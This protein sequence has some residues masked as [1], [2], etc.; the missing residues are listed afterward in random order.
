[1]WHSTVD[2]A[3]RNHTKANMK[4]CHTHPKIKDAPKRR[5]E[6]SSTRALAAS[7]M[8][9]PQTEVP[10]I[11]APL[12]PQMTPRPVPSDTTTPAPTRTIATPLPNMA[13]M[14]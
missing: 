13:N 5:R 9:K 11:E 12:T 7:T 8:A 4:Q 10:K 14:I 6:S 2:H 1:M 3:V